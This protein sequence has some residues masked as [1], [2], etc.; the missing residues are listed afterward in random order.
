LAS[1]VRVWFLE[2]AYAVVFFATLTI[3]FLAWFIS[4]QY[5]RFGRFA[6][7]PALV[8][9]A[10]ALYACALVAF[11]LF[12]F[13]NFD[14]GYCARRADV[15]HWQLNPLT[16]LDDISSYAADYGVLAT[17]TSGV[18]L[19]VVMNVVFFLPLGFFLAY[20]SRRSL[21]TT[22]LLAFAVSLS[23][24]LT[25]GTGLWGLAPC[26]YRLA[27][28]DD[29]LTNTLG[30]MLGW[31]IGAIALRTL[32]DARP[33]RAPDPGP[34]GAARQMVGALLDVQVYLLVQVTLLIVA[35]RLGI[36]LTVDSEF[37]GSFAGW[38]QALDFAIVGLAVT[39]VMF[40][41]IPRLRGDRA[42]VGFAS[43]Y[44][45]LIRTTT[46]RPA[47]VWTLTAR[48]ALRWL[49]VV[50]FGLVALVVIFPIEAVVVLLNRRRRSLSS[51][52]TRTE[53]STREA[54]L[55][56]KRSEAEPAHL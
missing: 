35:E 5:S 32:P 4:R 34:P 53:F 44:L 51:I 42:S 18:L 10:F 56:V 30:G 48:W 38:V 54:A 14:D 13:P 2:A 24:E 37:L 39:L 47:G 26:P 7:W 49:P 29:L 1:L 9:A 52:I 40:V 45:A 20:R 3:V 33:S 31:F 28:V 19:Q 17:L 55:G 12:P 36:T 21:P 41:L 15:D 11:T 23:I 25:Q 46:D 8:S 50:I 16:S 6:G 27:D 43:V 22:T